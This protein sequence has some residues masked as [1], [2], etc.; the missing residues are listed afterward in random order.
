MKTIAALLVLLF[1]VLSLNVSIAQEPISQADIDL[2][3]GKWS[4]DVPLGD[5]LLRLAFRFE[6]TDDEKLAAFVDM[7]DRGYN[8][9]P[10]TGIQMKDGD[11]KLKMASIQVEFT[12]KLKG[13]NNDMMVGNYFQGGNSYQLELRKSA[14]K[15]KGLGLSQESMDLL[16]GK[17]NGKLEAGMMSIRFEKKKSGEFVGYFD[18]PDPGRKG[19]P[20][21][22]VKL[23]DGKLNIKVE[24][25]KGEFNGQLSDKKFAGEWKQD[26]KASPLTIEK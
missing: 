9:V 6:I 16:L 1:S 20:I 8:N 7:P 19:V 12:G 14:S 26:G 18:N 5:D 3:I 11:I 10:I 24:S 15:S 22:A 2:L 21:T 13:K 23:K 4:G 25:I 17:W